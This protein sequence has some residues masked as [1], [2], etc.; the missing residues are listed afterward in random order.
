MKQMKPRARKA[1]LKWL[2]GAIPGFA[3]KVAPLYA[4]LGWIWER[5]GRREVPTEA[6]IAAALFQVVSDLEANQS[7]FGS[8]SGGLQVAIWGEQGDP[9]ATMAFT[10]SVETW[11]GVAEIEASE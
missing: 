8:S 3:H 4:S 6:N 5:Q 9:L 1:A 7:S 10:F 11:G 2:K